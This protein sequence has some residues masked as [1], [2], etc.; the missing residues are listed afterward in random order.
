MGRFGMH[1]KRM[2]NGTLLRV[3][4]EA[5]SAKPPG[6]RPVPNGPLRPVHVRPGTA[7]PRPLIGPGGRGT[8]ASDEHVRIV[9]IA[10]AEAMAVIAFLLG[11]LDWA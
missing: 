7:P 2:P 3:A 4:R 10:Q 9:P 5:T 6:K 11:A 1:P 8:P